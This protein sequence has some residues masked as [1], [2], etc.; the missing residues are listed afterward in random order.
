MT[1]DSETIHS[2]VS[3]SVDPEMADLRAVL[4]SDTAA[5]RAELARYIEG[6]TMTPT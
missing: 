1:G 3:F 5:V 2:A 6:I 4:N